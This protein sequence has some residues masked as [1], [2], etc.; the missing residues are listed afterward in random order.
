[1]KINFSQT[2]LFTILLS[3]SYIAGLIGVFIFNTIISLVIFGI[4]LSLLI[5][6]F[7]FDFKKSIILLFIFFLGI[8]RA[9]NSLNIDTTLKN[10]TSYNAVIKGRV[11]SSKNISNS[12]DKLKFY[13]KASNVKLLD[14]GKEENEYN[15]TN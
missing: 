14:A 3:L 11:V 10:I 9:Q 15:N 1:M 8:I 7:N 13:L 4:C 12:K 2:K 5:L 6:F